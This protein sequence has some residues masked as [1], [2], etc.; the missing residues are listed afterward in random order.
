MLCI[1]LATVAFRADANAAD[2]V[3]ATNVKVEIDVSEYNILT[4]T[5]TIDMEFLTPHHGIIRTLPLQNTTERQDESTGFNVAE[6]Y[7][8]TSNMP[9]TTSSTYDTYTIRIGDPDKTVEGPVQYVLTYKYDLGNDTLKNADE[10]YF[11]IIGTEWTYEI[12]H[13]QVIIHMPKEFDG[14]KVG[15]THG[16]RGTTDQS[17]ILQKITGNT[18]EF[19]YDDVL[20]PGEAFTVRCELPDK[21]FKV[22]FSL[23]RLLAGLLSALGAVIIGIINKLLYNRF[24]KP[25]PVIQTVEFYPPENMSPPRFY[26]LIHNNVSDQSVNGLLITLASKGYLTIETPQDS[27]YRI[28]IY[29]KP[30]DDLNDEEKIYYYGLRTKADKQEDGTR[31]ITK[32]LV[33][34]RFYDTIWAVK[35]HI[36][37]YAEPVYDQQRKFYSAVNIICALALIFIVPL[38]IISTVSVW[39]FSWYHWAAI[40]TCL[41]TGIYLFILA[42]RYRKRTPHNNLLYGKALG[43]REFI[44]VADRERL[45][46]LAEENPLY[47]YDILPYAYALGLTDTWMRKFEGMLKNDVEWYHGSDFDSFMSYGMDNYS[48]DASKRESYGSG[49]SSDSYDSSDGWSSSS[50]SGGGYSGG[51]SGGG[52]SSAW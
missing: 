19:R 41:I 13:L 28:T 22:E 46:A 51:G 35:T 26:H 16:T 9:Y 18:I 27:S 5:E 33:E 4:I 48:R 47:F 40:A 39:R 20:M 36:M 12:E 24:G 43:F 10:L 37:D 23:P 38:L 29:D 30:A 15:A 2:D 45:E 6:V 11:N 49:G 7:D 3:K 34:N 31:V 42:F 17:G 50:D 25:D 44:D 21:Y 52:G 8:V 1:L 14:S 32:E